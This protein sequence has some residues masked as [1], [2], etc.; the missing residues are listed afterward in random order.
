MK[1]KCISPGG[2]FLPPPVRKAS[3]HFLPRREAQP[4]QQQ[5]HDVPSKKKSKTDNNS[6]T[7]CN[8]TAGAA[9][10]DALPVA[11]SRL[12]LQPCPSRTISVTGPPDLKDK[13]VEKAV[14]K[15]VLDLY[16]K[17]VRVHCGKSA[18]GFKPSFYLVTE[19]PRLLKQALLQR[20]YEEATFVLAELEV[21]GRFPDCHHPEFPS[22][23][24]TQDGGRAPVAAAAAAAAVAT[25]AAGQQC[26][27]V[28]PE[29][30]CGADLEVHQD[31]LTVVDSAAMKKTKDSAKDI[32]EEEWH[33]PASDSAVFPVTAGSATSPPL[34]HA[35]GVSTTASV[36]PPTITTAA[37]SKVAS[38]VG[39][40]HRGGDQIVAVAGTRVAGEKDGSTGY[41]RYD[42]PALDSPAL[43]PDGTSSVADG[44]HHQ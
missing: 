34:D 31:V 14:E 19:P 42:G 33:I 39:F 15:V 25:A 16:S 26:W 38:V 28:V 20:K 44:R 29:D 17:V 13:A 36:L 9:P 1:G 35:A 23:P 41:K 12:F 11:A 27:K 3:D 24:A 2:G 7:A 43:V 21:V 22:G 30:R 6:N 37:A 40:G 10:K 8:K 4:Q 18:T 32:E 5:Q